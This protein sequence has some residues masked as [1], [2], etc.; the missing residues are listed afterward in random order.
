MVSRHT[1]CPMP[2]PPGLG[3]LLCSSLL[4]MPVFC[5]SCSGF[6]L[7]FRGCSRD[8]CSHPCHLRS[9][10]R[11]CSRRHR[12]HPSRRRALRHCTRRC[13][14]RRRCVCRRSTRRRCSRYCRR[15]TRCNLPRHRCSRPHCLRG[16]R[17]ATSRRFDP[18]RCYARRR[19][20]RRLCAH[21]RYTS[22]RHRR[23][24]R[25]CWSHCPLRGCCHRC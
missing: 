13:C 17:C 11:S 16:R 14:R 18:S 12:P 2:L 21:P 3:L 24:T 10:F 25:I 6:L 1:L 15:C 9:R 4:T 19:C 7:T 20:N 5:C 8:L 23:W 22:C